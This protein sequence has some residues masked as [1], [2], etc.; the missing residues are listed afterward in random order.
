[1]TG[2][3]ALLVGLLLTSPEGY[4][5]VLDD[6]NLVFHE[7]GHPIFALFGRTLGLLGGTLGQLAFPGIAAIAFWRRR[8]P[9]SVAIALCWFF[10]NFFSIGRYMADARALVLPLVGGDIHDWN[11]LFAQWGVLRQ[12]LQIA[13][14]VRS[15]GGCGLAAT[16]SWVAWR[17]WLDRA[18]RVPRREALPPEFAALLR[19][20]VALRQ[21]SNPSRPPSPLTRPRTLPGPTATSSGTRAARSP[22]GEAG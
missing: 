11:A 4:I 18:T 5:R 12:N 9:V 21:G 17:W 2:G 14:A 8:E 16:W 3:L 6:A 13:S 15:L 22:R 10:E 7:A 1:V 20:A 19:D